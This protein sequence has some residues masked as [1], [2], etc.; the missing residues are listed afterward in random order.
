MCSRMR[1]EWKIVGVRDRSQS[2]NNPLVSVIL[3]PF[4]YESEQSPGQK[5]ASARKE[6]LMTHHSQIDNQQKENNE[7]TFVGIDIEKHELVAHILLTNQQLN[8]PHYIEEIKEL[9]KRFK[10]NQPEQ[11]V[12]ETTGGF[13]RE[14]LTNLLQME[15]PQS[16]SI[17]GKHETSQKPMPSM[18]KSSPDSLN[19]KSFPQDPCRPV[20]RRTWTISLPEGSSWS[21]CGQ[22]KQTVPIKRTKG[23]L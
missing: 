18:Q 5:S 3:I 10:K 21:K 14:L 2:G 4:R 17:Q 9:I 8:V 15:S 20:K 11:A 1:E 6:V 22:W 7:T 23:T 16:P 19:W 12:L 13:G